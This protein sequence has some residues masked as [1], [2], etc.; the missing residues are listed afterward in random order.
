MKKVILVDGNNLLFR[1]FYA[2][3]YSGII[4]RNSKGFPTNAVYGFINMIHKILEEEKPEYILVAFDK[5]KTF[6]HDKYDWYKAGRSEMPEDL[7]L[8]FPKAKEVLEA[9]GIKYFEIENYEADDIIGTLSRIVDEEDEFIATIV[10]SDKDLLQLISDEVDVKLLKTSG[11]IRMDR[12]TFYNTYKVEPKCMVDLKALMGDSSDNIPGVKGIGEKTAI[13]LLS[14]YKTLD[15]LYKN[16]ENIKGKIHDKLVEGKNDA[17]MSYEIATIY[18]EVPLDFSLHDLKYT[19]INIESFRNIL[20]ELE[21]NSLLK[22]YQLLN[23][24]TT[25]T[26]SDSLESAQK[27]IK[28]IDYKDFDFTKDFSYYI[29]VD[30]LGYSKGNILGISFYNGEFATFI[31]IDN[32]YKTKEVF[33]NNTNKCTYDVKKS[34]VCLNKYDIEVKN[35]NFDSM[36]GAYLLD[37]LVK[38]DISYVAKSFSYDIPTYEEL[39]G[40]IK[41]SKEVDKDTLESE[42][43]I[44]AQFIYETKD[45]LLKEIKEND[46]L[47]LFEQIEMPLSFVLADME[48]TGVKVD[49]EYLDKLSVELNTKLIE[50]TDS[51]YKDAGCTFNIMSP[52]QLGDILFNKLAIA[53]P[54]KTKGENYST[55]KDILDKVIDSHPIVRKILEYRMIA[56]LY[57]NYAEGLK[58]EIRD[59]GR[60]HTIFNQTLT[61]TGRLSSVSPNLQN[62]PIRDEY[63]RL[64]RKAFIPDDNSVLL[65][66]D[67]SQVELRIFTH[68]SGIEHLKEAFIEDKDIHTK[69]ASDIFGVSEEKVTSDMRRTAKAVNFG[70]LYGIST[71]GLSEDLGINITEAKGFLDN[72]LNTYPGIKEYMENQKR[73]AYQNGFVKTLMNRRRV[74]PELKNKNYMIRTQGERIALN[75]PIQGTAA[76][77]LKKVMVDI[78]NEFN[79]RGIK[80]KMLIQVHDELIFNVYKNEEEEV[81][82]LVKDIMEN[83]YKLSVPL[84]VDIK[85]GNNWYEAK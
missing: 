77:I 5:G 25:T 80:S 14:E 33:N 37:Y 34:I 28:K 64:V 49:K 42:C 47:A 67:Y 44:K 27:E 11:F 32:I 65:S 76:D 29:E 57:T 26:N 85:T 84:K 40:T 63:G 17:Y 56:K 38:D 52:K 62:I 53:Y 16:I 81:T 58:L 61:R 73:E 6:R 68:V 59:D 74:I 2:T 66:S 9:M 31:D 51:I 35:V 70:I 45:V 36:I 83:T 4:M 55:S 41:K 60:I 72:Y 20:Q 23:T 10:S 8:Q 15:N 3:S 18:K 69:T 7:K 71:F 22:K 54:K 1:S 39:F 21:F 13:K 19:G 46:E 50:L 48:L 24:N 82:K 43:I 12:D 78:Y 79:K 30:H 75:T